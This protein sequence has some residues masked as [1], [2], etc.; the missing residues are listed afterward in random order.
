MV[1][2]ARALGTKETNARKTSPWPAHRRGRYRTAV[3]PTAA[4][5]SGSP[6][7]YSPMPVRHTY[8]DH[9]PIALA[10]ASGPRRRGRPRAARAATGAS[11]FPWLMHEG[12]QPAARSPLLPIDSYGRRPAQTH[13]D[14]DWK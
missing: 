4:R 8:T 14:V 6:W 3:W 9:L 12:V 2:R 7:A 13:S 1:S 11:G 5:G 10:A